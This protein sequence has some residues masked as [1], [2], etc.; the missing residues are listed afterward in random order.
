MSETMNAIGYY[1]GLPLEDV[2]ALQDVS[3]AKPV[4]SGHDILVAVKATSVNPVDV[5]IR[6][7]AKASQ[8]PQ[9][10]GWDAV[11]V[12][13]E[14]GEEVRKF[15]VGDRVYYSGAFKRQ[16]SNAAFQLVDERLVSLAPEKLSD[17]QAAAMPLTALTAY[18]L[19]FEKKGLTPRENAETGKSI[20]IINGAGGVGSIAI[21][22]AKWLGMTVIATASR[23]ETIAQSQ[24]M[25]ADFV[26]NHREDYVAAVRALGFKFVDDIV[27]LHSTEKHFLPAADLI[28]PFGHIASIVET[29]ES[30]PMTAIKNKSVSFD[31]EFMFAKANYDYQIET[32]GEALQVL[33]DLFDAGKLVSTLTKTYDGINAKNLR[34][35]HADIEA[36]AM[37]GKVVL[38]GDFD[39]EI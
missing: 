23:P 33:A 39:A 13:T 26:V 31:W 8:T 34:Q 36:D 32:Q 4:A 20:L 27:I 30:L 16:G 10:I 29:D 2:A 37:V 38:M 17:A 28:A 35:A 5:K 25:G 24:K 3:I 14:V 22:L 6:V 15:K 18:E 7:S 9:V 11:G 1:K 12:V 19:L 21:Q